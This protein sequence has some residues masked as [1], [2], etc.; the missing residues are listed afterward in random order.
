[1]HQVA[2][3]LV[4]LPSNRQVTV[5]VKLSIFL[6]YCQLPVNLSRYLPYCQVF[7]RIVKLLSESS[8]KLPAESPSYLPNCQVT[9]QIVKLCAKL[10]SYV[11][12]CQVTCQIVKLR[13]KLS[14]LLIR[15]VTYESSSRLRISRDQLMS[16]ESKISIVDNFS[17]TINGF[18]YGF[19]IL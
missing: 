18:R 15:Y 5:P 19:T 1:M 2:C 3:Q 16:S 17:I 13:A 10:S 11:P 7:C 14:S 12:N 4:N 8:V 9:C 6:L